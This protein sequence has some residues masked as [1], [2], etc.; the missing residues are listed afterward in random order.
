MLPCAREW[1]KR[2]EEEEKK[3]KKKKKIKNPKKKKK[4]K[5]KNFFINGFS[6]TVF[7]FSK[8]K[9]DLGLDE[10]C[11]LLF[12]GRYPIRRRLRGFVPF[13]VGFE[14]GKCCSEM[15]I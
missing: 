14:I 12:N 4:K 6:T 3:K 13:R 10:G 5:I 11:L 8:K 1:L 15:E 2:K 9:G 7:R